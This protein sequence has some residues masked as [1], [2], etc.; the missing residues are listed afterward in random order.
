M[1]TPRSDETAANVNSSQRDARSGSLQRMV[2]RWLESA[3][4]LWNEAT[5]CRNDGDI[6][7]ALTL[8]AKAMALRDCAADVNAAPAIVGTLYRAGT[9]SSEGIPR[10]CVQTTEAA[11]RD[12]PWNLLYSE[13]RVIL[14]RDEHEA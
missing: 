1:T 13:V 12:A 8:E 9:C 2:R 10:L 3:D 5:R 6:D 11:L 7:T 4:A 14:E